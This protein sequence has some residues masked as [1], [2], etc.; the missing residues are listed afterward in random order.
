MHD[1]HAHPLHPEP[2]AATHGLC[3][4]HAHGARVRLG[5][6]GRRAGLSLAA[7]LADAGRGAGDGEGTNGA[8]LLVCVELCS[9]AYDHSSMEKKD[10]VA[11]ALFSDG[12]AAAVIAPGDGPNRLGPFAQHCW[13]DTIPMMGWEIGDT[14]F[15]LVLSRDIPR[16][17]EKDFAPFC[18]AFLASQSLSRADLAEPACHPGG[19]RVVEALAAMFGRDLP[20]TAAVLRD[21]GNMS[22]PTVL[23]ILDR[24]LSSR[25]RGGEPVL[26]TALGP[27]FTGTAALV[28]P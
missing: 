22:S 17:V 28:H 11:L 20:A 14:G 9:L 25:A 16:F 6:R 27:G 1:R 5:L 10:L 4:D 23:F 15:D 26:V 18:D 3:A 19:G 13:P 7:T 12:C 8:L 21:Y 2:R 24:L